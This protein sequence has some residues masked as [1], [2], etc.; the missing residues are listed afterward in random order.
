MINYQIKCKNL[1][2]DSC[3]FLL[4]GN[5]ESELKRKFFNHTIINHNKE[6]E[7]LMETQKIEI[8]NIIKHLLEDQN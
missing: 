8:D 2:F 3:D 1:G 5:S 4:T 6:F 7:K